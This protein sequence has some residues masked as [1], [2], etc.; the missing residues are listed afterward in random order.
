MRG[1]EIVDRSESKAKD[2]IYISLTVPIL[3]GME[4]SADGDVTVCREN[5][6]QPNIAR[7]SNGRHR[8]HV[9]LDVRPARSYDG[10]QPVGNFKDCLDRLEQQTRHEVSGVG[11]GD[12]TQQ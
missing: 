2:R 3:S 4:R 9:R 12:G 7:L 8:P 1:H 10:R 5:D 6:N 11:D